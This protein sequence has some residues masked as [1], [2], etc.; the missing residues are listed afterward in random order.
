MNRIE[1][2]DLGGSARVVV[3]C[4]VGPLVCE[5]SSQSVR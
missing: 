5:A 1:N 3:S 2:R 4:S